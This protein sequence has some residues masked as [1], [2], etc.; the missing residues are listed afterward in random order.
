MSLKLLRFTHIGEVSMAMRRIKD[1]VADFF[2]MRR[3][4]FDNLYEWTI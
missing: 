4:L 3:V 2:Y 1:Y